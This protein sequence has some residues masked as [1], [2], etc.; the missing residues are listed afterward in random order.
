MV[1][2]ALLSLDSSRINLNYMDMSLPLVIPEYV[3]FL[4]IFSGVY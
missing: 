4:A 1:N 3:G 2:L